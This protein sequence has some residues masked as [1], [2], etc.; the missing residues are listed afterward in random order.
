MSWSS[1]GSLF[2]VSTVAHDTKENVSIVAEREDGRFVY[3]YHPDKGLLQF[4]W[5]PT[6]EDET[7]VWKKCGGKFDIA[8]LRTLSSTVGQNE[9]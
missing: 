6:K 1:G 8:S 3:L 9:R 5:K 7:Y 4:E 2:S